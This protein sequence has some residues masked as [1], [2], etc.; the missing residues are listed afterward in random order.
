MW[1]VMRQ[2]GIVIGLTTILTFPVTLVSGAGSQKQSD[3]SVRTPAMQWK[4]P[5]QPETMFPGHRIP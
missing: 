2:F 1:Q 4:R 3:T 5:V